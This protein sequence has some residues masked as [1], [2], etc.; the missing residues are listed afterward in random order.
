M[1]A[2]SPEL[3]LAPTEAQ[4]ENPA[5][6]DAIAQLPLV[7]VFDRTI[8]PDTRSFTQGAYEELLAM[9]LE[10]A[11]PVE[12]A[13]MLL[14]AFLELQYSGP[15]TFWNGVAFQKPMVS[16]WGPEF[17]DKVRQHLDDGSR[18]LAEGVLPQLPG[19]LKNPS[20]LDFDTI[21][22]SIQKSIRNYFEVG[23]KEYHTR[24]ATGAQESTR[25]AIY[26]V[27]FLK[28]NTISPTVAMS[29]F[30]NCL[31]LR[32]T[33]LAD[34]EIEALLKAGAF[35]ERLQLLKETDYLQNRKIRT[36][37]A[38]R[39]DHHYGLYSL[40]DRLKGELSS[41]GLNSLS[42][43]YGDWA[44]CPMGFGQGFLSEYAYWWGLI[45]EI[46]YLTWYCQA[47]LTSPLY[48]VE[49][50]PLPSPSFAFSK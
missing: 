8:D 25:L 28:L 41:V 4:A 32:S 7:T 12:R 46:V 14:T 17:A 47:Q 31:G 50:G 27:S 19:T 2:F 11:D 13:Q 9:G 21:Q 34:E 48:L 35:G 26:A 10:L 29:D 23:K 22:E 44:G 43:S 24:I 18:I 45:A 3:H 39:G 16:S 36:G 33:Q 5:V 42:Q 49:L 20:R 30:L 15:L 38:L 1:I 37:L 40:P 6:F